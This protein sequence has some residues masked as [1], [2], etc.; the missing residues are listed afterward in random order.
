[1]RVGRLLRA[2]SCCSGRRARSTLAWIAGASGA[3]RRRDRRRRLPVLR[4]HRAPG[5]ARVLDHR[6]PRGHEHVHLRRQRDRPV[7]AAIYR[8][9][10]RR[11][12]TF[13]V[14]L[15]LRELP[16]RWRSSATPTRSARR[17]RAAGSRRSRASRSSRPRCRSGDRRAALHVDRRARRGPKR[18]PP[19]T[20]GDDVA[21][22]LCPRARA[23][24]PH[25]PA[26][27]TLATLAAGSARRCWRSGSRRRCR[28]GRS[29]DCPRPR[30]RRAR[31]RRGRRAAKAGSSAGLSCSPSYSPRPAT[32]TT[33]TTRG[34]VTSRTVAATRRSRASASS[35]CMCSTRPRRTAPGSRASSPR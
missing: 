7:P 23:L 6:D 33:S 11:F 9:W 35:W 14:P 2:W 20:D 18:A 27:S 22:E 12:F 1:M 24:T 25:Q 29:P 13:V 31:A 10:F 28:P 32:P 4:P 30:E 19:S 5:D 15:A 17:S 8:P 16:A 3:A 26:V 34:A 21:R